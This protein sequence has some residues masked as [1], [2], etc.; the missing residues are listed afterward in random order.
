M[1]GLVVGSVLCF[2]ACPQGPS[3][4]DP[5]VTHIFVTGTSSSLNTHERPWAL[6]PVTT[7]RMRAPVWGADVR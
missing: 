4:S 5:L 1:S 6:W 3:G 2:S 7:R